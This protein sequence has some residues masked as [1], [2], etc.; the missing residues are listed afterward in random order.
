M[1]AFLGVLTLYVLFITSAMNWNIS[2]APGL[3]VKNALLY[4]VIG[5]LI[6]DAVIRSRAGPSRQASDGL[7]SNGQLRFVNLAFV[8]LLV[9]A[10][11]TLIAVILGG[12]VLPVS[13][14]RDA[15]A[16]ALTINLKN[17][18][19]DQY[20][21]FAALLFA[22]TSVAGARK[23]VAG[24]LVLVGLAAIVT[25][26]DVFN[27]PDLGII[28]QKGWGDAEGRI[29]GPVGHGNDYAAFMICFMPGLLV[30]AWRF[31]GFARLFFAV[32]A[33][34]SFVVLILTASRG[35]M[36]GLVAGSLVA[37]Y[38]LREYISLKSALLW[39]V[40]G[41]ALLAAAVGVA[42]IVYGDMIYNRFIADSTEGSIDVISSGRTLFWMQGLRALLENP[43]AF[44]TGFGW[45]AYTSNFNIHPHGTYFWY[46]Y[47]VGLLGLGLYLAVLFG[48]LNLI[49][50][51]I[52]V[53]DADARAVLVGFYVGFLAVMMATLVGGMNQPW[54]Y[55]WAYA[56]VMCAYAARVIAL[57]GVTADKE[58]KPVMPG[59]RRGIGIAPASA[60]ATSSRTGWDGRGTR[61]RPV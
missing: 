25:V 32:S 6:A 16:V 5:L 43:W 23:V 1:P 26:V 19:V 58:L 31:R 60:V 3:S 35:G 22:T 15:S 30:A 4:A 48:I 24:I 49:R 50:R 53:A 8:A 36:F 41:G 56:G 29:Y 20:L 27:I 14:F 9:Y 55:V 59:I 40:V 21:F 17:Q 12:F 33:V 2:L 52:A 46:L 61:P 13:P 34:C 37:A 39:P 54:N 44:I 11:C 28:E 7:L 38:L 18:L 47:D 57:H 10:I 42:G 45:G 51:A